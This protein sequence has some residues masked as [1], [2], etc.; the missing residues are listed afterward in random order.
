MRVELLCYITKTIP[1]WNSCEEK[2][3]STNLTVVSISQCIFEAN[4]HIA[5]CKL[6]Q[7][8]MSIKSHNWGKKPKGEEK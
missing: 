3:V 7:Y 2:D 5:H 4:H 8:Y 1:F 6:T